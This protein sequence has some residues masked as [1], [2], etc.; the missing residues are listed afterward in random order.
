MPTVRTTSPEETEAL[1]ERVG[2]VAQAG[3]VVGLDGDLGAGKTAFVRG[4]VRG[5]GCA[6]RAHSPTFALLHEYRG[7]R[8]PVHHLDLYRLRS[9]D[10]LHAAGLDSCLSPD[11][12]VSIIEWYSRAEG[13][14][15]PPASLQRIGFRWVDESTR[16]ITHDLPGL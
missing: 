5:L 1:G 13:L 15:P 4:F 3:W 10:E 14:N 6:A 2:R 9:A 7:G 8:L 11:D 16:E 12:A